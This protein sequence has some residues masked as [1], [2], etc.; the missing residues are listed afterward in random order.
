MLLPFKDGAIEDGTELCAAE[1]TCASVRVDAS[2]LEEAEATATA[3]LKEIGFGHRV[4]RLRRMEETGAETC[5][6]GCVGPWCPGER[7]MDRSVGA[8]SYKLWTDGLP[9]QD[10][11]DVDSKS[12]CGAK[13]K[14][15]AAAHYNEYDQG[16]C[17]AFKEAAQ[18]PAKCEVS[19]LCDAQSRISLPYHPGLGHRPHSVPQRG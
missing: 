2:E 12:K 19:R 4:P 1:A 3:A 5:T 8:P 15:Y 18:G 16:F 13:C 17:C 10:P 11:V 9:S 7:C 14:E 6:A